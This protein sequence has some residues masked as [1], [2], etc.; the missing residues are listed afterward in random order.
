MGI[1]VEFKDGIQG[2]VPA[3]VLDR[4]IDLN[5][6]AGFRRQGGWVELS[7][8]RIRCRPPMI[9]LP[10]RRLSMQQIPDPVASLQ[11]KEKH[12]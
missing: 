1:P 10:E 11:E 9:S 6:I 4:L 8:G 12:P 2:E 5:L 3:T 7:S